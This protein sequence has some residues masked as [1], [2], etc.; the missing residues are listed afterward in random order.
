MLVAGSYDTIARLLAQLFARRS[1]TQPGQMGQEAD[2]ASLEVWGQMGPHLRGPHEWSGRDDLMS[3]DELSLHKAYVYH[4]ANIGCWDLVWRFH[5]E[6][7]CDGL[8]P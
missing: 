6:I 1:G 2:R 4:G 8:C 5:A 7:T 3:H